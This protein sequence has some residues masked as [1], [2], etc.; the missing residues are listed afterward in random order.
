MPCVCSRCMWVC[1]S[2]ENMTKISIETNW[3]GLLW[4]ER[5]AIHRCDWTK[6][7]PFN[8]NGNR[9]EFCSRNRRYN[10]WKCLFPI[11]DESHLRL[12]AFPSL[13][14]KANGEKKQQ[15]GEIV[16]RQVPDDRSFCLCVCILF[17]FRLDFCLASVECIIGINWNEFD[18]NSMW[19]HLCALA[20]MHLPPLMLVFISRLMPLLYS[21]TALE[22]RH[23]HLLYF[24][25]QY[26]SQC[27]QFHQDRFS[28]SNLSDIRATDVW[29]SR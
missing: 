27:M 17:F 20:K 19:M 10:R 6:R 2:L 5:L 25:I 1:V 9:F 18:G 24:I 4:I 13:R 12:S 22:Y 29:V 16:F 11:Y 3:F 15:P 8:L 21:F 7:S 23:R 26:Q 28:N 14:R